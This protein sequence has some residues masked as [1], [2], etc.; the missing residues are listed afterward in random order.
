MLIA[1]AVRIEIEGFQC[2]HLTDDQMRQLNP[3]I[4][5]GIATA[6]HA[7]ERTTARPIRRGSSSTSNTAASRGTGN[8]PNCWIK[9]GALE[10]NKECQAG[11]SS[12]GVHASIQS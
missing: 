1:M 3:I 7:V 5:N 2:E 8:R 12:C 10:P 4:R 11:L 9:R 6:L